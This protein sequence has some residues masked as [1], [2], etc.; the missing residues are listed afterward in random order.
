[1]AHLSVEA[2]RREF[3]YLVSDEPPALRLEEEAKTAE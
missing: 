3:E 2:F 1:V